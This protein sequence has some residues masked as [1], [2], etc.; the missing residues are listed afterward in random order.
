MDTSAV[1]KR[2]VRER[3]S[4]QIDTLYRAAEQGKIR[5]AYSIWN[6]GEVLGVLDKMRT[7]GSLTQQQYDAAISLYFGENEKLVRLNSLVIA[8]L[9]SAILVESW[10]IIGEQ[11]VYAADAV[12]IA[13][14]AQMG[15]NLFL[16]ADKRLTEAASNHGL[17]A[18]NVEEKNDIQEKIE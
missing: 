8:P 18:I 2:Y 14:S 1:T 3:G 6:V 17:E 10:R 12:Q 5:L 13:T 4:D 11:H 9:T 15:A 7:R 16:T